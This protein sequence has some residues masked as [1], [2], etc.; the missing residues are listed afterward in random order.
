MM[1]AD[2]GSLTAAVSADGGF[3]ADT[4]CRTSRCILHDFII[5]I[6]ITVII[7]IAIIFIIVSGMLQGHMVRVY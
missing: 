2:S 5:I 4:G 7:I 3:S 6:I 1:D